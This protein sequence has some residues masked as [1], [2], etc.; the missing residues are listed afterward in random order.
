MNL[1]ILHHILRCRLQKSG[2]YTSRLLQPT[3]LCTWAPANRQ[4]FVVRFTEIC[5]S[6]NSIKAVSNILVSGCMLISSLEAFQPA[7]DGTINHSLWRMASATPDLRWPT[8]LQSSHRTFTSNVSSRVETWR[9]KWNLGLWLYM[10]LYGCR[11][12]SARAGIGC[13]VGWTRALSVRAGG[14]SGS[15]QGAWRGREDVEASGRRARDVVS[16]F[17]PSLQPDAVQPRTR[18][19]GLSS[20]RQVSCCSQR[21]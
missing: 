1:R 11:P 14:G 3:G 13:G 17:Q 21:H 8:Q 16:R 19:L 9:A 6:G 7:A 2:N 18:T 4:R 12:K 5:V 20:R 15:T 10:R